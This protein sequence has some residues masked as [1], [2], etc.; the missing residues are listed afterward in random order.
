MFGASWG[1]YVGGVEVGKGELVWVTMSQG[2][3]SEVLCPL[4]VLW[5]RQETVG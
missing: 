3:L 1:E 2:W 4:S 5:V